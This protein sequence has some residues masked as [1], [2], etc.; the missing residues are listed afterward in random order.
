M[1]AHTHTHTHTLSLLSL[2]LSLSLSIYIYIYI[3]I[4]ICTCYIH[5][6]VHV[7]L[8]ITYDVI[9]SL[10]SDLTYW[11]GLR[12]SDDTEQWGW[13]GGPN[14]EGSGYTPWAR[15]EPNN[16]DENNCA[17]LKAVSGKM[18]TIPCSAEYRVVC[19]VN[20]GAIC[21]VKVF[22]SKSVRS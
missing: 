16:A 17:V 3:Y 5:K 10:R 18:H 6:H 19:R 13:T 8:I 20:P 11:I 15:H 21:L 22:L 12:Y 9:Y 4:Y 2:S 14:R 7:V 1:R